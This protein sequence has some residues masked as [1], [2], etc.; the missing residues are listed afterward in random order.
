MS[1]PSTPAPLVHVVGF[2]MGPDHLTRAAARVLDSL[3]LVVAF[4][5]GTPG[6]PDPLL[7]VRRELCTEFQI[8]LVAL[9]DPARDRDAPAD[10][11]RAV[12]DWHAA[13][14]DLLAGALTEAL[15]EHPGRVGLLVWG[16]P[17]LYDSTLRLLDAVGERV[18]LGVRVE[19]GIAAPQVLAAAHGVVL[20]PV[21]RPV[22]VTTARRL[23]EAV[24]AGQRDLC[25]MLAGDPDRTGPWATTTGLPGDPPGE[26]ATALAD[27]QVHWGANLGTPSQRLVSGRVGEVGT[28]VR[29][30][31][32]AAAA[33]AGWVMDA[34]LLHAPAGRS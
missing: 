28:Q 22:H 27:W 25:V 15:A 21:G 9:P 5:K 20:H 11:P 3:A 13:R 4:D 7:E 23:G 34:Y 30:A 6:S 1:E 2:G 33:E 10:Y 24:E 18:P 12:R 29:D 31:R 32:A 19:P 26:L 17:S 14:A 8:T 16:D